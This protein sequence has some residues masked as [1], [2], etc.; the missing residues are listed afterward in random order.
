M[1]SLLLMFCMQHF[2]IP[3][4]DFRTMCEWIEAGVAT[5]QSS[6]EAKPADLLQGQGVR[7]GA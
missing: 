5:P 3:P 2:S 4:P 7:E 1:A 6:E